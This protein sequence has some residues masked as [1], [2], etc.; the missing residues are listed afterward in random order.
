MFSPNAENSVS[1]LIAKANTIIG[2]INELINAYPVATSYERRDHFVSALFTIPQRF[3]PLLSLLTTKQA[4]M[5]IAEKAIFDTLDIRFREAMSQAVT[6]GELVRRPPSR[7]IENP[8]KQMMDMIRKDD[9]TKLQPF[10]HNMSSPSTLED[11]D[12]VLRH[13]AHFGAINCL[14]VL[15][16][17]FPKRPVADIFSTG[18]TSKKIA[19]HAA[20]EAGHANCVAVLLNTMGDCDGRVP[21]A[22]L[23]HGESPNRPI[24]SLKNLADNVRCLEVCDAIL[25]NDSND[26]YG[27]SEAQRLTVLQIVMQLKQERSEA[28]SSTNMSSK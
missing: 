1:T 8:R 21:I 4:E 5:N 22:Q 23:M 28:T 14:K 17:P 19:M 15:C 12:Y 27:N 20:I 10:I 25:A 6:H 9:A 13:S 18:K 3:N 26:Y 24:D 2:S 7:F 16:G 11:L